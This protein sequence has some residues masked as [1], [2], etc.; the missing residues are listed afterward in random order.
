VLWKIKVVETRFWKMVESGSPLG[1][2]TA[3]LIAKGIK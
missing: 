1:I 2:F 3:N